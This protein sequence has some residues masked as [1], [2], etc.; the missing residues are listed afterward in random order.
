MSFFSKDKLRE[1]REQMVAGA[2]KLGTQ[3]QQGMQNAQQQRPR[4]PAGGLG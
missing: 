2:T 3:L 1:M 4:L